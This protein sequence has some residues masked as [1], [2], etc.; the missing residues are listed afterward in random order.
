MRGGLVAR[1]IRIEA[2]VHGVD[3]AAAP[4]A[5]VLAAEAAVVLAA[6]V[7]VVDLVAR[8]EEAD[9]GRSKSEVRGQKS[10]V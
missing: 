7:A 4:E 5:V 2:V 9:G 8:E 10:D 1:R 6:E 3:L